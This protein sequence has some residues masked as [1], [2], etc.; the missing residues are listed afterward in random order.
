MLPAQGTHFEK[1]NFLST[2]YEEGTI[3]VT[4]I[5]ILQTWKQTSGKVKQL[6]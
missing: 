4:I 1:H 2:F 5:S 3:I 6:A